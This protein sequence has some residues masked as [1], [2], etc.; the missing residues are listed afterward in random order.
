[1]VGCDGVGPDP[2]KGRIDDAGLIRARQ[3]EVTSVLDIL[4]RVFDELGNH[5]VRN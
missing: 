3:E 5:G 4:R 2:R 1:M